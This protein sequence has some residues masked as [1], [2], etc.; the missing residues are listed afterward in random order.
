[1]V[2]HSPEAIL[3]IQPNHEIAFA[4][5]TAVKFLGA[6]SAEHLL[7]KKAEVFFQPESLD[8]FTERVR[9]VRHAQPFTPFEEQQLR[10]LDGVPLDV[11][12]SAAPTVYQGKP[13][14]QLICH[15]I[16]ER[17]QRVEQ[18]RRSEAMKTLVLETALDAIISVDHEG[19]IQEWNPAARKIFGY[20]R[21]EAVGQLMDELIVPSAMWDVYQEGLTNYLMTGVG[22]LIGRPIELPLRRKDGSEFRAEMGISRTLEENPPR[23]TAVIRDITER[24]QAELS[25]RQSEERLRLLV[26]N[27][28]DYAIY[29]LD[30]QGNVATWNAGAEHTE[31]Y[32][33]EEIIGKPFSTFFTPEDVARNAPQ[34]FLKRAEDEGQ[35]LNEGWRVRKD[36]SR[37][38]TQGTLTALHHENGKLR[39]FS[40]IAHDITLQK[41]AEDKIRQLNEQLE[42]RVRDRTAQLEAA[43]QELEAFSYSISHDL[44]APLRHISGY[45]EILQT[46]AGDKLDPQARE[47]LQTIA[48]SAKNLGELIDALLSFS[49]MGRAEMHR[50]R[51]SLAALVEEAQRELRREAEGRN[52]EWKIGKL[53]EV[54]GDPLMIK[55]VVINLVSNALKYTRHCKQAKIHIAASEADEETVFS[56]HDNGVGFDMKYADKL[57]GVFQRLHPANKFEGVG[58]GLANVRRIVQ[59][60][61]GRTWAEGKVD[62]GATFY[63]SMPK[64]PK[65]NL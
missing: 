27:A 51:V 33:A 65:E 9:S 48:G 14:V 47:H 53:T 12:V 61:G 31:G 25:L 2:E 32:R 41:E 34:E 6:P 50:Q 10:R 4:N 43:N 45:I 7:G 54:R 49:R 64:A 13:A 8:R 17:K 35:V 30:A 44:R 52:I 1:M 36:G 3:V 29:M 37:F 26:E 38:W 21:G 62:G 24:K 59:R 46:E 55:Q 5:S 23:C 39:G 56:I 60:H 40:K 58:I 22:S 15:D 19:K 20:E 18:L 63:F 16:G 28:K 11:E 57:F 42:Q